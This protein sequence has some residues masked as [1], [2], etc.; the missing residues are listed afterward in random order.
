MSPR[1]RIRPG[2]PVSLLGMVVGLVFIG[3]GVAVV[4]PLFGPFGVFWTLVAAGIALYHGYNFFSGR[5]ASAYDVDV[6]GRDAGED[7]DAKLRKLARLKEDGLLSEEEYQRK[8]DEI[9]RQP[10]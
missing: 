3:L 1:I 7:F 2:R 10:W 9:V 4:I 8:R 5:G 6:E